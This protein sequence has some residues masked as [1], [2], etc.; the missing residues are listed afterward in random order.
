MD[1]YHSRMLGHSY[2]TSPD[3][4]VIKAWIRATVLFPSFFNLTG[5]NVSVYVKIIP[6]AVGYLAPGIPC[7]CVVAVID[8]ALPFVMI[9]YPSL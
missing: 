6:H 9:I 8:V 1:V 4:L 3:Y 5:T 7:H 2:F